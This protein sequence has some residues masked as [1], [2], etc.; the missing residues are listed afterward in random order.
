M[1]KCSL[2]CTKFI[3]KYFY[4]AKNSL[5]KNPLFFREPARGPAGSLMDI[6]LLEQGDRRTDTQIDCLQRQGISR[7][8]RTGVKVKF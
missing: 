7:L 8:S 6:K 5:Y 2:F 3:L 1:V 4:L